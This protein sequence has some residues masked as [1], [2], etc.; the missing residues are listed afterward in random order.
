MQMSIRT[1]VIAV[2]ATALA[3]LTISGVCGIRLVGKIALHALD[4]RASLAENPALR[5]SP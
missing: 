2:F 4:Q 5:I 3:I 1:R